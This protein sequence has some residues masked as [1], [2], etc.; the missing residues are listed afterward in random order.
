MSTS[1]DRLYEL[2]PAIYRIRDAD[3]GYPL[4]VLLRV[5]EEQVDVVEEDI[6]QLYDNWFIETCQDWVVPYIGDLIG[7]RPLHSGGSPGRSALVPRR[8]VANTIGFRRRKGTL[9]LLISLAFD[10]SAWQIRVRELYKSLA[11]NQNL[12]HLNM[13]RGRTLNLREIASIQCLDGAFDD[14]SYIYGLPG[15]RPCERSCDLSGLGI[16][17]W[18][19]KSYSISDCQAFNVKEM[20]PQFYTFSPLGNDMP[21]FQRPD[22][23]STSGEMGLPAPVS[24]RSFEAHKE[25]YYGQGKSL[26]IWRSARSPGGE[27]EEVPLEDIQPASLRKWLYKPDKGKVAVDPEIGRIAFPLVDLPSQVNVSYYYGFSDDMGGGEYER[28]LSQPPDSKIYRVGRGA[29]ESVK[30][31]LD[32]WKTD[33]EA[34][35]AK[36]AVIEIMDSRVYIESIDID[37]G[38]GESLQI[39]AADGAR[40]VIH[41]PKWQPGRSESMTMRGDKG[42]VLLI[43]GLLIT[44]MGISI[45]GDIARV[46]ISHSTLVPGWGMHPDCEPRRCADSSLDLSIPKACIC[47]DHSITGPIIVN[48][49]ESKNEPISLRVNDSIIDSMVPGRNAI[50]SYTGQIAHAHLKVIDSTILGRLKVHSLEADNSIF[51]DIVKVARRLIGCIRFCYVTPGS[52]TPKRFHCQPDIV[53]EGLSSQEKDMASARVRPI[54]NSIRYG[55]PTYCQLSKC[56]AE[57]IKRGADDQSEMGAFHDLYQPQRENNLRERLK[58]YTP[59]GTDVNIIFVN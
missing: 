15:Q 3:Q 48:I 30:D 26:Q 4:K 59:V 23:E 1:I 45:D 31:A 20:G 42:S 25:D 51:Y 49:D 7:Y 13:D 57:E 12:N 14:A 55:M 36:D 58:E 10:A 50:S 40:P 53:S 47:I 29:K 41:L 39:R 21:L 43:N 17:V 2:L 18:R 27:L 35:K 22:P 54:F 24:L 52:R 44:G 8:E 28:R 9:G 33:K 6:A 32:E 56:C 38:E 11:F 46:V 37:L 34:G 5:V 16:F 19:L